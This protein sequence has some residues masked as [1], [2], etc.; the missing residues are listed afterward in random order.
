MESRSHNS[1]GIIAKCITF[2]AVACLALA[3]ASSPALAQASPQNSAAIIGQVTGGD[4]SVSGTSQPSSP[5][6]ANS[7]AFAA[8]STIVVHSGQARVE[9]TG[10]GELDVCG[11]AKFTVLASGEALTIALNFGRIHAR[12]D[13]SRPVTIYAPLIT[14]AP[15]AVMSQ[16]RDFTLGIE[17]DTGA[18]CVLAAH[19]ALQVQ[20]QLSGASLIIP[21]PSEVSLAANPLGSNPAAPGSCRCDFDES[22]AKAAP[23]EHI[24]AEN[25]IPVGVATAS[26]ASQPK[27]PPQPAAAAAQTPSSSSAVLAK[28]DN[29]DFPPPI[30]PAAKPREPVPPPELPPA[31][32]LITKIVAPPLLYEA[33]PLPAPAGTISVATLLL[34]KAAVVEQGWTIRGVVE[35]PTKSS[36]KDSTAAGK[37]A[38]PKKKSG[39]W[40][41]FHRFL[42]GSPQKST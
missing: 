23:P 31:S 7:F 3:L 17:P 33:K 15:L 10:G 11:P 12:L 30:V 40:A 6:G 34:A 25:T 29:P 18:I 9:F 24:V 36:G 26:P 14:A 41:W 5:V 38:S 27:A 13:A 32:G 1:L 22:A 37:K 39:F 35:E 16:P 20:Q 4:V 8:G 19:G 2:F 21:E 28:S 42:F